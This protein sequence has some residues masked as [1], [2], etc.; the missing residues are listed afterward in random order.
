M[1]SETFKRTW[2]QTRFTDLVLGGGG[3]KGVA[4]LGAL[5]WFET[6]GYLRHIVR[7]YGTSIGSVLGLLLCVGLSPRVVY[8]HL[9]RID[10]IVNPHEDIST[11]FSSHGIADIRSVSNHVRSI[12][13]ET[14]GRSASTDLT[15]HEL[16][17][18]TQ[19]RELTIVG[20]NLSLGGVP[21][22]FNHTNTPEMSVYTAIEISCCL[23][24]IFGKVCF[25]GYEWIDGGFVNDYP[26]DEAARR[27]GDDGR[28]LGICVDKAYRIEVGGVGVDTD[29]IVSGV[30]N[31]LGKVD[32]LPTTNDVDS[33]TAKVR[34]SLFRFTLDPIRKSIGEL[35]TKV[36]AVVSAPL[37]ELHR[38]RM[39][40]SPETSVTV[41]IANDNGVK[42]FVN[43]NMTPRQKAQMFDRGETAAKA[44]VEPLMEWDWLDSETPDV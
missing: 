18:L 7:Y 44:Q 28:I 27:C 37:V 4:M 3:S 24:F 10:A 14:L 34:E 1:V 2:A 36:A 20:T 15:F 38:L 41:T 22:L 25:N 8:N 39:A 42:S 11:V 9:E 19:H 23:P 17:E 5:C 12:V 26:I 43:F 32:I 6:K 40:S 21:A 29:R 13:N 30:D 35:L 16:F 33:V 31:E